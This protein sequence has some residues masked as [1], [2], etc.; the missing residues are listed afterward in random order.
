M[1]R[2]LLFSFMILVAFN[3]VSSAGSKGPTL[4]TVT[5]SILNFMDDGRWYP[6]TVWNILGMQS[7][8]EL[9]TTIKDMNGKI[10]ADAT[11]QFTANSDGEWAKVTDCLKFSPTGHPTTAFDKLPVFA[12]ANYKLEIYAGGKLIW[13]TPFEITKTVKAG[14]ARYACTGPWQDIAYIYEDDGSNGGIV[15]FWFAGP[16]DVKWFWENNDGYERTMELRS[17]VIKNGEVLVTKGPEQYDHFTSYPGQT[18]KF[19][20]SVAYTMDFKPK[21]MAKDG[22]YRIVIYASDQYKNQWNPIVDFTFPVVNGKIPINEELSGEKSDPL[23]RCITSSAYYKKGAVK[24]T[25]PNYR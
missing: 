7:G 4:T 22:E 11:W 20:K 13:E 8:E 1:K 23:H 17:E 18:R 25:V 16:T 5:E 10:V 24:N 14:K 19:G 15:S 21:V 12:P 3:S 2:L 6:K 9:R